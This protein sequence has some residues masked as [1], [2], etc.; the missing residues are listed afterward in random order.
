[1]DDS[2]SKCR[3]QPLTNW[4]WG[5]IKRGRE[6]GFS[7]PDGKPVADTPPV[8]P[9]RAEAL[10]SE[11]FARLLLELPG[12]R[13]DM[14]AAYTAGNLEELGCRVHK[15]LGGVAYCNLP[16]LE[17]SLRKLQQTLATENHRLISPEFSN[18]LD[19]IDGLMKSSGLLGR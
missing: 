12:F 13:A 18:T 5:Y 19:V 15:L 17:T 4:L 8:T 11:L 6:I 16:D 14:K 1:M 9:T 2:N 3:K 10:S 7:Q